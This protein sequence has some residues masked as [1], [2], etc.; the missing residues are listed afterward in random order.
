MYYEYLLKA[1]DSVLALEGSVMRQGVDM[2]MAL[3][4]A[5]SYH[6]S[7]KIEELWCTIYDNVVSNDKDWHPFE[8]LPAPVQLMHMLV[9]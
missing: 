1:D 9:N 2:L 7:F 4:G 6:W 5:K 3:T 8:E